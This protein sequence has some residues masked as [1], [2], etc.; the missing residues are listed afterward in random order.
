MRPVAE[1]GTD[2]GGLIVLGSGK[3]RRNCGKEIDRC[4]G[5]G[6]I[7]DPGDGG[8]ECN[9]QDEGEGEGEERVEEEELLADAHSGEHASAAGRAGRPWR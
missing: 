8:A 5:I 1:V 3:G 2:W 9:K 7:D 6:A 4:A